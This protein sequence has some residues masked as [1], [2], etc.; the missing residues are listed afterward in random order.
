MLGLS[1]F[2]VTVVILKGGVDGKRVV[3]LPPG[4]IGII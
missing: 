2:F 4:E 3:I 1:L